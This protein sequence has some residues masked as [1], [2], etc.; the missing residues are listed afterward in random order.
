MLTLN[1]LTQ[2]FIDGLD[3]ENFL[4]SQLTGDVT[5]ATIHRCSLNAYCNRQGYIEAL[6]WLSRTESGFMMLVPTELSERIAQ[7]LKKYGA[8]AK[9]TVRLER[10]ECQLHFRSQDSLLC[11]DGDQIYLTEPIAPWLEPLHLNNNQ[12]WRAYWLSHGIAT[13]DQATTD[14]FRPHDLNLIELGA[15]CMTKGCYPGQEI[16]ARMH[17]LGKIKQR[18]RRLWITT[19]QTLSPGQVLEPITIVDA[20]QCEPQRWAITALMRDDVYQQL[21]QA[22]DFGELQSCSH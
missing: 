4:Q 18:L 10:P 6:A 3:A 16:V 13:I 7:R 11:I 22:Y 2:I 12:L 19:D 21:P 8:F 9:I 14:R 5:Q 20:I 17:Y 1:P 15:V